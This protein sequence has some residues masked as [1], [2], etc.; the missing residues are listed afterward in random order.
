MFTLS[1]TSIISVYFR[2][3][4]LVEEWGIRYGKVDLRET[5]PLGGEI[6]CGDRTFQRLKVEG[7]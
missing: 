4:F 1:F 7:V 3:E 5:R 2:Q 6:I